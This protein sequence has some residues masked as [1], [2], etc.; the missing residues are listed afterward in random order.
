MT[1]TAIDR[2]ASITGSRRPAGLL[3]ATLPAFVA[4]VAFA[5]LTIA[6]EVTTSADLTP[7]QVDDLG[8]EWIVL[9]LLWMTPPLLAAVALASISGRLPGAAR[10]ARPLAAVT[11]ICAAGYV[12]VNLLAYSSDAATWGADVLYPWSYTLSLAAGWLGVLP[13]TLLVCVTLAR[14]GVARRTCWTVGALVAAYWVL[15][16]LTYLPVLL[17]SSTFAG[18][19]G[20][21]PPFLLGVLWAVLG[22]GL[23]RSGLRSDS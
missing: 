3:L 15:E 21:L 12:V 19:E 14:Q 23:L 17:G 20:G 5:V 9:H 4:Y 16:V 22:G 10:Y 8:L 2:T 7:S 6:K 13:A 1:L 18:F 11:G